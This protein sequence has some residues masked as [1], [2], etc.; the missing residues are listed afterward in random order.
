MVPLEPEP[1]PEP[2]PELASA[3]A[4]VGQRRLSCGH[5]ARRAAST[6]LSARTTAVLPPN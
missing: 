5:V 3:K 1:E 4:V 2:E 6:V